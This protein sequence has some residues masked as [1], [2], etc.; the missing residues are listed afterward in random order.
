[1]PRCYFD[2]HTLKATTSNLLSKAPPEEGG[3]AGGR[4]Q[5]REGG[6]AS[7][8]D[9]PLVSA[10][11]CSTRPFAGTTVHDSPALGTSGAGGGVTGRRR[12]IRAFEQSL[13]TTSPH[14]LSISIKLWGCPVRVCGRGREEGVGG[15]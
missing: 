5:V 7:D 12:G 1:M 2:V 10:C 14:S 13:Q 9:A 15:R 11:S 6:G 3:R 4:G 8:I